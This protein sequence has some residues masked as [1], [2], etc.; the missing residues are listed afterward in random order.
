MTSNQQIILCTAY[1]EKQVSNSRL[2]PLLETHSLDVAKD[3]NYLVDNG[4][5]VSNNNGRWT[6][7][8]IC[9]SYVKRTSQG[10]SWDQVG[11]KLGPSQKSSFLLPNRALFKRDYVNDEPDKSKQVQSQ[12]YCSFINKR[13]F[14]FNYPWKAK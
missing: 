8:E 6:T 12:L 7:Y 9:E 13:I 11:T 2:Q 1:V 14:E 3:L 5:L 10:V 4:F